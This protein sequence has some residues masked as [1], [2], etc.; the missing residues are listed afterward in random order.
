MP[1][2]KDEIGRHN[3]QAALSAALQAHF[4]DQLSIVIDQEAVSCWRRG[5]RLSRGVPPPPSKVGNYFVGS[6]WKK[7]IEAH[8]LPKY[9]HSVEKQDLAVLAQT[10]KYQTTIIE[11]E[12]AQIDLDIKNG[13]VVKKT[14]VGR[15]F[16]GIAST[17]NAIM[18][19]RLDLRARVALKEMADKCNVVIDPV[20]VD[21]LC[22][23]LQSLNAEIKSEI[24]I[25]VD[26]LCDES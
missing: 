15:L 17:V 11:R 10:P 3:T 19:N 7:W 8:I 16:A 2:P 5:E 4:G 14:E 23:Y 13:S 21:N 22:K 24:K 9:G 20:I 12:D 6:Q 18:N 1:K 25:G 26:Q